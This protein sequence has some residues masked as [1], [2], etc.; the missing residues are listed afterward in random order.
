MT[1]ARFHDER[2]RY[3]IPEETQR[4]RYR[5]GLALAADN[6]DVKSSIAGG[7]IAMSIYRAALPRPPRALI[8]AR[9]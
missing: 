2:L 8:G 9:Q 4:A 7:Y 3:R 6:G 1:E 5:P